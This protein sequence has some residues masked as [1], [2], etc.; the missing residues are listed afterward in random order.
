MLIRGDLFIDISSSPS[1]YGVFEKR[2]WGRKRL[3][4]KFTDIDEAMD[5]VDRRVRGER[6]EDAGW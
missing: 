3:V 5:F 6:I 1:S 2:S 4:K